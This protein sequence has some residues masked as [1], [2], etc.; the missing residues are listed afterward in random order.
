MLDKFIYLRPITYADCKN[1]Y[2]WRK[3]PKIWKHTNFTW[4]KNITLKLEKLFLKKSIQNEKNLKMAIIYFC[5]NK[6]IHIGNVQITNIVK[7]QAVFHIFIG[8]I[9][10]WKRGYGYIAT[11]LFIQILEQNTKIRKLKLY[12]HKKNLPAIKLY[13]RIGFILTKSKLINESNLKN[14]NN[15]LEMTYH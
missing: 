8:N 5:K 10:F 14:E 13:K 2:N 1:I 7:D 6:N 15:F 4:N 3:N 11:K 9:K 12:V